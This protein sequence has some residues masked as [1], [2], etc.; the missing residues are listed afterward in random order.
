MNA[1][2]NQA[3][4]T[5]R[6]IGALFEV[7]N[8]LGS[9]FLEKVYERALLRE[10]KIRGLAAVSQASF[11][12]MYKGRVTGGQDDSRGNRGRLLK[13]FWNASGYSRNHCSVVRFPVPFRNAGGEGFRGHAGNRPGD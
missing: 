3:A 13:G 7:S 6:I 8:T 11:R 2:E 9:G 12:V 5:E 1:D 4:L 10:L